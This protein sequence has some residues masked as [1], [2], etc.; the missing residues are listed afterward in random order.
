M[1]HVE[2]RDGGDMPLP[3]THPR[4]ILER[5]WI[6]IAPEPRVRKVQ[7]DFMLRTFGV[8]TTNRPPRAKTRAASRM[9]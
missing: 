6:E 7:R 1:S 8:E 2:E 5:E 4:I 3:R 9:A